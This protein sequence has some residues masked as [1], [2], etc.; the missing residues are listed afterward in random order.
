MS[1]VSL[2]GKVSSFEP[3]GNTKPREMIIISFRLIGIG[4]QNSAYR[5]GV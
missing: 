4:K 3:G 2:I 1:E 5:V